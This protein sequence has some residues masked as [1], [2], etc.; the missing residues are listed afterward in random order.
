M[1]AALGDD[2][3]VAV[4]KARYARR[5]TTLTKALATSGF[6]V[7]HSDAGLY[8]WS[9]R[10]EGSWETLEWLAGHGILAAPG[11]FYGPAGAEHVRIALTAS[12]E[13]IEAA[14]QRLA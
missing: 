4:Q 1:V 7:D 9:S 14:A 13:R 10:G 6:R 8:L 12:D 3:H 11:T 5:R 2:E